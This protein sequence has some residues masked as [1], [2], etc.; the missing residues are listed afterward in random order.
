LKIVDLLLVLLDLRFILLLLR[1]GLLQLS[2][3]RR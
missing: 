1:A 2:C 3:Q